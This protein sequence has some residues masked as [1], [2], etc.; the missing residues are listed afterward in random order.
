MVTTRWNTFK[1]HLRGYT[2]ICSLVSW[3]GSSYLNDLNL[4]KNFVFFLNLRKNKI[5]IIV[6]SLVKKVIIRI[7]KQLTH[8]NTTR[9]FLG[10][11]LYIY[12]GRTS[13]CD[14]SNVGTRVTRRD[15]ATRC[16]KCAAANKISSGWGTWQFT[17]GELEKA[18]ENSNRLLSSVCQS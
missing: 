6:I 16:P 4:Y 9:G 15:V 2:Q 14:L 10:L 12:G 8:K 18:V 3:I 1:P 17:Q 5:Y 11:R 13:P 7:D